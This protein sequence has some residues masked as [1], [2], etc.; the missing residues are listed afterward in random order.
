MIE[1]TVKSMHTLNVSQ[2]SNEK[3]VFFT[4]TNINGNTVFS[5]VLGMKNVDIRSITVSD[6]STGI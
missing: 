3:K 6:S 2:H 4:H 1:F 5:S